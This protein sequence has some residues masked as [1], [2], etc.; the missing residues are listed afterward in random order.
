M[1]N[2]SKALIIAGA[3]LIAVMLVSLGVMLYNTAAGVAETTTGSVEALGIAGFN[4]QFE[5]YLGTGKSK[6]QAVG[7]IAKVI[8]NNANNDVEVGILYDSMASGDVLSSAATTTSAL[9]TIRNSIN[10]SKNRRYTIEVAGAG[11]SD[12]G[13]NSD[14]SIKSIKITQTNL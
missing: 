1:D 13:F 9:N 4:A 7:L 3:I 10:S 11:T 14:G 5:T 2:A 6:S 12:T 8:S